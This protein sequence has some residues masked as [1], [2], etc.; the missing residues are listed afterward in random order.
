LKDTTAGA[1]KISAKE[2]PQGPEG[3]CSRQ[4][5]DDVQMMV[6][7]LSGVK[8]LTEKLKPGV[9]FDVGSA[10]TLVVEH[11]FSI[12]RQGNEMP[13]ALEFAHKFSVATKEL[14]KQLCQCGFQLLYA[15]QIILPTWED[16][17]TLCSSA[18]HEQPQHNYLI[19]TSNSQA[20]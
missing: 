7:S 13:L 12:M 16:T 14:L 17:S 9:L 5:T 6:G 19:P 4:S 10:G 15:C 20:E 3:A 1:Q 18:N 2:N 11:L 8:Q